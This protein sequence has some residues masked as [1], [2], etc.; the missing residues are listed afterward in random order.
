MAHDVP[1]NLGC[2]VKKLG[3]TLRGRSW[4]S[5]KVRP[6]DPR[7]LLCPPPAASTWAGRLNS[8][9]KTPGFMPDYQQP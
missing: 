6:G 3:F 2:A 1:T 8:R 4:Y 9:S 5:W 7:A